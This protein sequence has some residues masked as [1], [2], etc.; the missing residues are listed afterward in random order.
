MDGT[1]TWLHSR[2]NA[3]ET[4]MRMV[5]MMALVL[6]GGYSSV[7]SASDFLPTERE[8][9][10]ASDLIEHAAMSRDNGYSKEF[11]V[12]RF[13]D[14]ILILSGMDPQKRWFVRSKGATQFLRQALVDVFSVKRKPGD[15]ASIFR[16][17][18]M[19]HV[20]ALSPD[21]L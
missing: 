19:A 3:K 7:V 14:D 18:C 5:R 10:E 20:L 4:D 15:Q 1:I 2:N 12:K 16:Q 13:D 6:W 11:L 17:S 9:H 21:D 8:C